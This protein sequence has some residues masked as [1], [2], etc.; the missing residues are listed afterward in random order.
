SDAALDALDPAER[1]RGWRDALTARDGPAA[2]AVFVAE[3]DGRL[4]G[5]VSCGRSRDSEADVAM[6]NTGD[7]DV[8]TLHAEGKNVVPPG[9]RGEVYAM[10]VV[11]D[12]AGTGLG[13]ALLHRAEADLRARG[14]VEMVLWVLETNARA[15]RFYEREGWLP[16]GNVKTEDLHGLLLR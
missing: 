2:A 8:V 13:T 14:L 16:D 15:R 3:R 1:A 7:A 4:V 9:R 12:A 6:S 10:Y 5:F 11:E